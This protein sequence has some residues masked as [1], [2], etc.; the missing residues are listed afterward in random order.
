MNHIIGSA[1]KII[2]TVDVVAGTTVSLKD[3]INPNGTIVLSD[4]AMSFNDASNTLN[5]SIVWQ[6][7]LNTH[8]IGRYKYLVKAV[9]SSYT[10]ISKGFFFLEEE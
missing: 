8:V 9:N 4:Q 2:S 6:S 1:V 7:T 3:L 10:S 5:A